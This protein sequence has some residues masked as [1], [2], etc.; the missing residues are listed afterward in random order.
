MNKHLT[1]KLIN[2]M[3]EH[4]SME[5]AGAFFEALAEMERL[6]KG[7]KYHHEHKQVAALMAHIQTFK[8]VA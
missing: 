4:G 7:T 1:E 3:Q 2:L 8:K 6:T 5:V